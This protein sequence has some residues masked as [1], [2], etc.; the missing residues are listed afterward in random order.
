MTRLI[1]EPS[2]KSRRSSLEKPS[3]KMTVIVDYLRLIL[4][5]GGTL[6][7]V[8]IPGFVDQYGRSLES[9]FRE[10]KQNL[11]EFQR[12]ADRYFGGDLE[13]LIAHYKSDGDRVFYAGGESIDSIYRRNL[14]LKNAV[15]DFRESYFSALSQVF[16]NPISDIRTEVWENY[17]YSVKLDF[18]AIL[19]GLTVGLVVASLAEGLLRGFMGLARFSLK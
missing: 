8:Q 1:K 12:D 9:H 14:I 16:F 15:A 11:D 3:T 18:S 6:I 17:S 4:F 19:I 10:S 7:G 13:K 5:L 2:G